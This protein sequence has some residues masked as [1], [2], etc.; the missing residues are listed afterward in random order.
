MYTFLCI[1]ASDID[2]ELNEIIRTRIDRNDHFNY[3]PSF[4]V[5][6]LFSLSS[7][8][9]SL[10]PVYAYIPFQKEYYVDFY[11]IR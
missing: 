10:A 3:D 9:R 4:F 6:F 8:S 11:F 1:H 2:E 7:L 5:L